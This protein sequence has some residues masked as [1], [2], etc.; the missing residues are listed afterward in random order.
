MGN[1]NYK[2][3]NGKIRRGKKWSWPNFRHY[4]SIY[5]EE[6]RHIIKTSVRRVGAPVSKRTALDYKSKPLFLK[7]CCGGLSYLLP[8]S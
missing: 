6:M 7:S 3:S 8:T 5:L 4:L 1:S 2:V